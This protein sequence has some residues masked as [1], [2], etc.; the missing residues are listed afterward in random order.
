[1]RPSVGTRA[2]S[3]P[4]PPP[5]AP[6]SIAGKAEA[7]PSS[8][9]GLASSPRDEPP[10]ASMAVL[11]PGGAGFLVSPVL[12][13][14]VSIA[15]CA[16]IAAVQRMGARVWRSQRCEKKKWVLVGGIRSEVFRK[17]TSSCGCKFSTGMLLLKLCLLLFLLVRSPCILENK[18]QQRAT[19]KGCVDQQG[20]VLL[21][22]VLSINTIYD[23][24]QKW[25][26]FHEGSHSEGWIPSTEDCKGDLKTE[27][28]Q[29]CMQFSL[30]KQ[31][32]GSIAAQLTR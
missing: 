24:R 3:R 21:L 7:P 23:V 4:D 26:K 9:T 12:V 32:A 30:C 25:L 8:P 17:R 18:A 16:V 11:S 15:R 6:L 1:M 31:R 10:R 29:A 28:K 14:E 27:Q 2:D 20:Q 13:A 19:S 5:P 22:L